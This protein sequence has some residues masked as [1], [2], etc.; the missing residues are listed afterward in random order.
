MRTPEPMNSSTEIPH[1]KKS[2]RKYTP[3]NLVNFPFCDICLSYLPKNL[4]TPASATSWWSFFSSPFSTHKG[5]VIYLIPPTG[6]RGGFLNLSTSM[7]K[8]ACQVIQ[9]VTKL[10]IPY[11][12]MSPLQPLKGSL[13]SQSQKGSRSQNWK[14][15]GWTGTF[16]KRRVRKVQKW[17]EQKNMLPKTNS[18]PSK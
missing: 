3:T 1:P 14:K 18:S 13:T 16:P 7:G 11:L 12:G 9:A 6:F 17:R 8:I 15:T 4:R 10:Y 5:R 2:N